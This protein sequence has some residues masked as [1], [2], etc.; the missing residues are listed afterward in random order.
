MQ[1]PQIRDPT[2]MHYRIDSWRTD[3]K[4]SQSVPAGTLLT[5]YYPLSNLRRKKSQKFTKFI[6]TRIRR[7]L[8]HVHEIENIQW[9]T[10]GPTW[11]WFPV[12]DRQ[13]HISTGFAPLGSACVVCCGRWPGHILSLKHDRLQCLE[14]IQLYSMHNRFN[15]VSR[16]RIFH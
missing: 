1:L 2:A 8:V 5:M 10:N 14:G 9:H 7:R 15:L 16:V 12:T 13:N 11:H 4:R 3:L 6:R